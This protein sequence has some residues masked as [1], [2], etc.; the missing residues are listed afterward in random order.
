MLTY[1]F[2]DIGNDSLYEQLYKL[3]KNDILNNVL[4][5]GY[6]LPSKRNFAK[7]LNISTITIENAYA[8]LM[9]EGYIYSIPKK[10]Y[11][12]SEISEIFTEEP[13]C[14]KRNEVNCK[15]DFLCGDSYSAT[16]YIDLSNNHTNPDNFPFT[17]WAKLVRETLSD[18]RE[19][20]MTS[21]PSTGLYEL[22][23][24]IANH[25]K[26][27][28]DMHVSPDQIIIGAGT[29][30]LYNIIIQLL[31]RERIYAVEDPGYKKISQIYKCNQ[32]SCRFISMQHNGINV[33][34]LEKSGADVIHLSPSHHFP[35]GIV[36]PISKRY[37]LLGWA[38][39]ASNQQR[40]IIEDDYDSE[41]RLMGKPIPSLQGIDVMERVIYM[42]SFSKS[43]SS[44]IRI[45]YMVL[46]TH[47][48]ELYNKTMSFYACTVSNFEQY[49]LARF[50]NEGYFEKHIN[51]MRNFYRNLRD[52]F[53]ESIRQSSL[54]EL[55]TISE[56]DSG[57]H[58]LLTLDTKLSDSRLKELL[59]NNNVIISCISD[60]YHQPD[61]A[62]AHVIIANYSGLQEKDFKPIINA[63]SMA[64]T[65]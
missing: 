61:D 42:N 18:N 15:R 34:E 50:I 14:N 31:G 13:D 44:T 9:A 40:Y 30:Y 8:Q 25:L 2:S 51:R 47:L 16:D 57:L 49:T 39:K 43:L 28:R 53:I 54:S 29:E 52:S 41:F 64:L 11:Y 63:L 27:Y 62:P 20:L 19:K 24:A 59:K 23:V 58:F 3:I 38:A 32:V 4:P 17:I 26:A 46:P 60:Y 37:E 7:N 6:K 55:C 22:R 45:S 48:M 21:S 36:T 35:T 10:G 1:S 65:K 12:V 33:D 5:A 56:A